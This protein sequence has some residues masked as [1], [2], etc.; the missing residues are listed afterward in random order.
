MS[1][2]GR[3]AT[4]IRHPVSRHVKLLNQL[5]RIEPH[6]S[7]DNDNVCIKYEYMNSLWFPPLQNTKSRCLCGGFWQMFAR[8]HS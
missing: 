7:S 2:T 1:Q 6:G 3:T 5:S 8:Q 4:I